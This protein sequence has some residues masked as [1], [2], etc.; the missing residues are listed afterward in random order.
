M[1]NHQY[2]S[3]A[4]VIF[5]SLC[6]KPSVHAQGSLTPPGAPAPTM[7][8]ADQ[9][10]AKLEARIPVGTNT[11]PG[12]ANNLFIIS[13]PGSYILTANIIGGGVVPN[14]IKIA[15]N[16]VVLDLNGFS[17]DTT[18]KDFSAVGVFIDTNA[19]N[20]VVRNG[21]ISRWGHEDIYSRAQGD[22][23]VEHVNL[24]DSDNF[25]ILALSAGTVTVSDCMA[26]R[27]G[28]MGITIIGNGIVQNC[29]VN[30]NSLS[31]ANSTYLF[32]VNYPTA[33]IL[34]T[35][36]TV[37]KCQ[38]RGNNNAGISLQSGQ[39]TEC[40]VETS[41]DNGIYLDRNNG[42]G[43]TCLKNLLIGNG[44]SAIAVIGSDRAQHSGPRIC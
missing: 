9:I 29:L 1:K 5:S 3:L 23:R 33:G 4:I 15:T 35:K 39:V 7:K 44:G 11:T 12:D 38:L 16:N 42:E 36:G 40:D 19:A 8:T 34:L 6:L 20:I 21:T 17:L 10:Y 27:N 26:T 31:V 13:Q 32:G 37:T 25:G 24:T 2:L 30:S 14:G 28:T 18:N 22:L 41:R 43:A